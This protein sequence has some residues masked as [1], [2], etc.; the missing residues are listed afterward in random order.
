MRKNS[1]VFFHIFSS[2]ENY[3]SHFFTLFSKHE[4]AMI[5]ACF[6]KKCGY[7][8]QLAQKGVKIPTREIP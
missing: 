5:W 2:V 4:G 1:I 3:F 6:D 7:T 8:R